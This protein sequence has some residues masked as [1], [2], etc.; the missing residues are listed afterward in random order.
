MTIPYTFASQTGPIPLSQLDSNFAYVGDSSGVTYTPAGTGAVAT[1]VQTKLRESVSVKDFGAVGNGSTDDTAAI[2][3]AIN[4]CQNNLKALYF[5][6]NDVSQTYKTSA[7]LSITKPIKIYGE[8]S[9]NVTIAAAGLAVGQYVIDMDGTAFGTFEQGELRGLSLFGGAGDCLRIKN[10]SNSIFSDLLL[11]NARHGVIY[12]GT[13]CFSN[14]FDKIIGQSLSGTNFAMLAHTGG[15]Q[16]SFRECSFSGNAGFSV[17][18][19]TATDNIVFYNTNFEQCVNNGFYAGGSIAGLSFFGCRT[20]GGDTVDFQINP[21][22]GNSV[23]G[24][25]IHGSTFSASD[26]GGSSR[27]LLGGAGGVVRGF[28]I[29]GNTVTHGAHNY[30]A[31]FV[32][33]NGEGE[34]G[35]VANNYLDGLITNCAPVN[36]PLRPNV[37]VFNN[38]GNNGKFSGTVPVETTGLWTPTDASGAALTFTAKGGTY[39]KIGTMLFYQGTVVYPAT[40]NGSGALLGGLPQTIGDPGTGNAGRA[41]GSIDATDSVAASVLQMVGSTTLRLDKVNLVNATNAELSGKSVYFS[42]MYRIA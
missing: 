42:G 20:E 17:D 6:G 41:G 18:T 5:P 31:N 11:R 16:H 13:R 12:T 25:V 35:V 24:L 22:A 1:T 3:A 21:T 8:G 40:A 36:T 37:S 39:N 28:D 14:S 7:T 10:I 34:S 32:T 15:G 9:R 2:Q 30:S 27:I 29:I 19:V 33:L 26:A 38:E 23:T 4:Y